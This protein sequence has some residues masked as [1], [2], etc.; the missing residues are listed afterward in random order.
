MTEGLDTA[1][2]SHQLFGNPIQ[3]NPKFCPPPQKKR[4][5]S[6]SKL[7]INFL[8]AYA[9]MKLSVCVHVFWSLQ[10]GFDS[11]YFGRIDYQDRAKRKDEKSLEVVW[12]GSKSL[13]SSAQVKR[14]CL[15]VLIPCPLTASGDT[16][17]MLSRLF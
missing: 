15:L 7:G 2:C 9:Y 14:T 5:T 3:R 10:L 8:A 1:T 4:G 12:R 16:G 17:K 11:L 6:L 13:G